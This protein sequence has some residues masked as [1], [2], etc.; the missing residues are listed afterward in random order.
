MY[1]LKPIQIHIVVKSEILVNTFLNT[2]FLAMLDHETGFQYSRKQGALNKTCRKYINKALLFWQKRLPYTIHKMRFGFNRWV[3]TVQN[4]RNRQE[5]VG[6][7]INTFIFGKLSRCLLIELIRNTNKSMP[8][9]Y[10]SRSHQS[11]ILNIGNPNLQLQLN[12]IKDI[13]QISNDSKSLTS[14]YNELNLSKTE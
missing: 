14:N 2:S 9:N 13:I 4:I 7:W 3:C 6:I 1:K 12:Y 8:S 5:V 11:L 10:T